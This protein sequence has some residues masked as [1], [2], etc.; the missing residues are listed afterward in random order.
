VAGYIGLA[1]FLGTTVNAAFNVVSLGYAGTVSW[2]DL[3]PTILEWWVPNALAGLVVAPFLITWA[4][5]SALRWHPRLVMEAAL[6]GTGLV[7]GTLTSFHSWFVYGIESYPL[8]YL[9]FPFLVWGALRFG[10]RGATTGTL[11]VSALA[12]HS[13]L[14]GR[15]PFVTTSEREG[16][17]LIGSYIGILAVTNMLLA[18][19]AAERRQAER[20]LAKSER[21]LRAVVEDQTDSICRF[22]P[23]GTLA[24]VNGAYC[25]FHGKAREELLGTNF[26]ETLTAEDLAIP[27]SWFGALPREQ[28][29]VSFDHRVVGLNGL[30]VWQ[31]YTV[32]R[33][34]SEDGGTFEFQAVIQDITHRKQAEEALRASEGKYR[35]LLAN[36]PDVVWTGNANGELVYVSENVAKIL[37]Y[38]AGELMNSGE[39]LWLGRIHPNDLPS[40]E[41]AHQ[42]LFAEE[43]GFDIEYR[44][45][46]KDGDWIWLQNRAP[47]THMRDGARCAEG[48]MSEITARKRVEEALQNAKDA[49]EAAN[50]AKSQFLASMSHELRTPLNAIIGFSEI[51]GDRIFGDLNDRQ[52]KYANNILNSGRH[53][54]QLINDILD[55]SKVEAGKLELTRSS[56]SVTRALQNV[57]AIVKTLANK[58]NLTLDVD[59]AANLPPLFADEAKFKQ[60]L[61]NLLSN[62]I[63]FT[64]EKGRIA[65][66]ATLRHDVTGHGLPAQKIQVSGEYLEVT[67]ADTGI[68]VHPRDH[69]RIFAEFEQVDSSYGRQQQGTGLG[70][71]L[72]KRLIELH[73]GQIR[74]ESEGIEGKGSRFTFLLPLAKPG[75]KP[76]TAGDKVEQREATLRPL[77]VVA[78]ADEQSQCLASN[79]LEGVGYRV[80][81]VSG[82]DKLGA[83]LR[84]TR[85]YVVVIDDKITRQCGEQELRDIRAQIPASIPAVIYSTAAGEKLGFILFTGEQTTAAPTE[86]RLVDAVRRK[87]KTTGKEV[88]TV[89]I[90]DDE[91]ALLELLAKTLLFKGFQVLPAGTGRRGIEFATAAHP[92]VIILDLA[93]PDCSGIQVVEQLRAQPETKHIPILIHTGTALDEQE[94]QH[95]AAQVQSITSKA[96][97]QSL[98]ADLDRLEDLPAQTVRQE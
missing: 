93:M 18:A 39:R 9:P 32:R 45:R 57:Q 28:P 94:R 46:R 20:A 86:S 12:I 81:V 34:F 31:Q 80:A 72:S 48:L 76:G 7:V 5:P 66:T 26:L 38:T 8:A 84:S 65:V 19:A 88:K 4:T 37:G 13:L 62:A 10:Q 11:L 78:A 21:R 3:F 40:V 87:A 97:P 14:S 75:R 74:I 41:M 25:L 30:M 15:G 55:L 53:L 89:L 42:I 1:C 54:L 95:L 60:I 79:Y 91:P 67:V 85:P 23:D 70:L 17:M 71:A 44:I 98:F 6:C 35:S 83:T 64:P 27:L 16:L 56:F 73:G 49:A 63:K 29:V 47:S 43:K 92:D 33:L 51:L 2:T 59:V 52:L 69:E 77:V 22:K 58:K 61:Y 96:A 68:G 50:R 82:I 90:I 36:I 24:F